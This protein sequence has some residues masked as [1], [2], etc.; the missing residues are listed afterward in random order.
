MTTAQMKTAQMTGSVLVAFG[1]KHGSTEEVAGAIAATLRE[2]ELEVM[3]R[4]ASEVDNLEGYDGVVIGAALYMGRVH[5]DVRRLLRRLHSEL[6]PLPVAVF[7]MGPLTMK[8][9]DVVASRSQLDATLA[10]TPD[11][12]PVVTAIFGGVVHPEELSF[13]FSHMPAADAR[14]WDA[15]AKWAEEV[16]AAF[17]AE[18]AMV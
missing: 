13:P 6:A 5:K 2:K 17:A 1:T 12:Q 8:P 10:K 15:I 14:D 11:V 16:A 3:L 18:E 7:A 4:P 9:E